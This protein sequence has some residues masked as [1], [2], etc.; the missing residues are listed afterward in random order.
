M[1]LA[2]EKSSHHTCGEIMAK[3]MTS[4]GQ[5]RTTAVARQGEFE[6]FLADARRW[7]RPGK[8]AEPSE[9]TWRVL[10]KLLYTYLPLRAMAWFRFGSW[11]KRKRIPMMTGIVQRQIYR[12]YGLQIRVG[13][14]IGGGLYVAH[15]VGCVIVPNRMGKNCSVIAAATIGMRNEWVFPTI[16]DDVFIGAGA[17]VLGDVTLGDGAKVGANAVVIRDVSPN[18]TVAGV[19]ARVV[20]G[21]DHP[22]SEALAEPAL[23]LEELA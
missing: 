10:L 17:R 20:R 18:T 21:S 9:L 23:S 15:P 7:V 6:L 5:V 13:A 8:V 14:E 16:G 4:N 11:C 12:R 3:L 2:A 1:S 19:P 22:A